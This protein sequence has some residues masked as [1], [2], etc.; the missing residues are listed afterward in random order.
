MRTNENC[1]RIRG[2]W[3]KG[4]VVGMSLTCARK[5]VDVVQ[6]QCT[7]VMGCFLF[8]FVLFFNNKTGK[9]KGNLSYRTW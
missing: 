6:A 7:Q 5:E 8:C 3:C 2:Q 4:P 9:V 1:F